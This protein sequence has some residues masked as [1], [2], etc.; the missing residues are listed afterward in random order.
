ML[1]VWSSNHQGEYY[2]LLDFYLLPIR[3]AD[4]DLDPAR[5][6][7]Y[8][9]IWIRI[10]KKFGSQMKGRIRIRSKNQDPT[11]STFLSILFQ[12]LII[13][14]NDYINYID[15]DMKKKFR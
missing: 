3:D 5:S 14:K 15:F 1:L 7:C 6:G 8:G 11:K 12:I 13:E 9:R 10:S 2:N 4:P